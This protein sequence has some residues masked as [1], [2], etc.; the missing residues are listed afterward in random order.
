MLNERNKTNGFLLLILANM[1][2]GGNFVIGRIGV[3]FFPPVLFSLMRWLI[4]FL[5]L[6]PFMTKQL[7]NDWNIIRKH[8]KIL[9]LLAVTGIAGYNTIIYFA[10]QYTTSINASVVNST[11]PL[12][13]AILA[14]F[15]LR[16]KLLAHHAAGIILSVFGILF[17]ISKG[18]VEVFL[19][20]EI[21]AGDFYVLAAVFMW[22]L[23]SVIVKKYADV[24]PLVS[25]F[26]VSV[27]LGIFLLAP[28]SLIE[29]LWLEAAKP[30]F[31][32]PSIG[33]LLYVGFLAS[34]MAFLSWNFGV[35]IIGAAKAGVF[36][37]LLPVFAIIFALC[38]TQEK[39]YLYQ[40]IGGGI[41]ILGVV[42][43]SRK[44]LRF[45]NHPQEDKFSA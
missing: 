18:S 16:E 32:L 3:D 29:Y 24:L 40:I 1:I 8:M 38:F 6:T 36:L 28:L 4:A 12:F 42:L 23:Y 2:W 41:V 22:A 37:N 25:S 44:S 35:H 9:L 34:I 45:K 27:F 10:L 39:L 19:S 13:I 15:L 14:V 30:V 7:K 20:W 43:S 11:T 21:N 5:L 31:T 26:Y 17:V 33:I